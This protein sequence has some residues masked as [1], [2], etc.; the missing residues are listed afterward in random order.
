LTDSNPRPRN[1][2]KRLWQIGFA[3]TLF[4]GTATVM[5]CFQPEDK[6]VTR[7]SAGH[8]FLAFYTA[9]TFVRTGRADQLYD[10]PAVKAFER[11]LVQRQGLELRED[12]F[13]PFWNPPLLAWVFVP[14]SRLDYHTAW[15]TWLGINLCCFAGAM[16]ILCRML[17]RHADWRT[18]AL[19]PLLTAVS[20]PFIQA[21]GHGQNTCLSLLLLA[22]TVA[23]WRE[24]RAVAAGA[25]AGL[26]FYKP[27]LATVV[28]GAMVLTLGWRAIAGLAITGTGM[29]LATL[30]TLPGTIAIYLHQLPQ[31]V[32]YMQVEH[33]YLWE[34]H[35]TLKA[36]WRLLLQG[37]AIGDLSPVTR[38][39]YFAT[40]LAAAACVFAVIWK[41]RGNSQSRDRIIALTI[42]VMPLLMPF[43]FDYDLLLLSAAATLVAREHLA[44][45]RP[46]Q[47]RLLAG[48]AI[49]FA[50]SVFNPAIAGATHVNGTV[51]ALGALSGMM[52]HQALKRNDVS[53]QADE[54]QTP[55]RAAA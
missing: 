6:A 41:L 1:L 23:L 22:G 28:A 24:G 54:P 13:G 17:S 16:W 44:T 43:Y 35:V 15:N 2:R 11:E 42:V 47:R 32:V 34:R 33:R 18:W 7:K 50:Q 37:Y 9:G 27:Q 10:L 19:V 31:N 39:L 48:W 21:L 45:G 53:A 5:N 8:D 38:I 12:A 46:I 26:L 40:L 55:L 3:L 49:L 29:L 30:L 25:V 20:M 52:M 14:L 51:L 36:F 4:I